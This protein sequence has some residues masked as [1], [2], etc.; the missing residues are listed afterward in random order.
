MPDLNARRL[1][2]EGLVIVSSIL[3]A[4][5]IDA[6]WESWQT[7]AAEEGQLAL[8][9][10]EMES[11]R[12]TLELALSGVVTSRESLRQLVSLIAPE[13]TL[14]SSDS[15]GVLIRTAI[16]GRVEPLEIGTIGAVLNSGQFEASSRPDLYQALVRFRALTENYAVRGGIFVDQRALILRY[17]G[18]IT[19]AFVS[20]TTGAHGPSDFPVPVEQLLGDSQLEALAGSMAVYGRNMQLSIED[21]TVVTDSVLFLL[22]DGGAS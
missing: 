7:R 11:N 20:E 18:G 3:L 22:S 10:A 4:F 16:T 17:L 21:L 8:L 5:G 1:L 2:L 14:I 13:P 9:R 12:T 19:G 15:L 6:S